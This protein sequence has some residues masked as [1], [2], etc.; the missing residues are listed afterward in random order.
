MDF[1]GKRVVIVGKGVSGLGAKYALDRAGAVCSF[2][3][4][5]KATAE[6]MVVSPGIR[7]DHECFSLKIPVLGEFAVGALLNRKPVAAVTGTQRQNDGVRN[8]QRNAVGAVR[9][10]ACRQHRRLVCPGGVGRGV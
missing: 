9:H 4:A 1:L 6:L 3:P 10:R 2:Y 8:A 5:G 7:P